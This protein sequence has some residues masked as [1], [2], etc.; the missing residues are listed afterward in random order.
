MRVLVTGASG[1][2]GSAVVQELGAQG[3]E[4]VG[5]DRV[6]PG[7]GAWPEG[8]RFVQTDLLDAGQVAYAMQGCAAVIHLGAIVSPYRHPDE[9]VF[10]NNTR[11]TYCVLQAASLLGLKRA[12]IA[13]SISSY[14][15]DWAPELSTYAWAPV[16]ES[17]PQRPKDPYGLG[18]LVDEQSAR[19]FCDRDGMSI[20]A[21]RFTWISNLDTFRKAAQ[22]MAQTPARPDG[23]RRLWTYV[24]VRDAARACRL[25]IEA[26]PFGFAPMNIAAADTLLDI[27]TED[28]IRQYAPKTELRAAI[29]GKQTPFV[30]DR[31][32]RL[33]DW[34]PLHSWRDA[35]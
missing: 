12:A 10:A 9:L 8:V 2:L 14:G 31:A 5:I 20:A 27:P 34:E 23:L 3:Y 32:R 18:K 21:F 13:S 6:A 35:D 7:K 16:D 24:D 1:K 33:I 26:A 17:Y 4:V 11:A 25:A 22:E 29:P 15:H 28:A 19:M 30:L